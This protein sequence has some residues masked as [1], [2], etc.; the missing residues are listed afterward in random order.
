M[1]RRSPVGA[2]TAPEDRVLSR[3]TCHQRGRLRRPQ[4]PRGLANWGRHAPGRQPVDGARRPAPRDQ[5]AGPPVARPPRGGCRPACRRRNGP[6]CRRLLVVAEDRY[7]HADDACAG[8]EFAAEGERVGRPGRLRP[9]RRSRSPLAPTPEGRRS[10]T[11]RRGGRACA[12]ATSP[13]RHTRRRRSETNGD[14]RLKGPEPTKVTNFL[15]AHGGHRL[16][17]ATD[18]PDLPPGCREGLAGRRDGQSVVPHSGA[19]TRRRWSAPPKV[20]CS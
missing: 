10:A 14:S 9:Q 2:Q 16:R 4:R 7:G 17:R 11:W 18:P 1:W 19:A 20:R 8:G 6:G 13:D 5:P 15:T 3:W 12:P